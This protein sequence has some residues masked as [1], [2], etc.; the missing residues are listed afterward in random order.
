M[1]L[2]VAWLDRLGPGERTHLEHASVIG[3]VYERGS[4]GALAPDGLRDTLDA[5]LA[6]LV[7]KQLIQPW[8]PGLPG[9]E[10]YRF[11]HILIRD[12]AYRRLTKKAR[13]GLHERFA[14]WL[15]GIP[16]EF[17]EIV[18]YHLEQACLYLAELGEPADRR[19]GLAE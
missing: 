11:R 17:D 10:G 16:G 9:D 13:A 2:A 14:R 4:V 15:A 1:S 5:H 3:R 19:A 8:S 6:G 12:G 7:R 18:G